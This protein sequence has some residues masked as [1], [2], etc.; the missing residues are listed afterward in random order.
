[1]P[2]ESLTSEASTL[3]TTEG[4][5]SG[6]HPVLSTFELGGLR[7]PNRVVM[8][9]M[10][11]GRTTSSN[12]APIPL[13]AEYYAQRAS[14][15]LIITGGIYIS[16]QATGAINVPGIY[17]EEHVNGWRY[18][19]DAVHAK[20]GRIFAQLGHSGGVSHP[21]LQGGDLPVAPS[22][23]NPGSKVFT[24]SGFTDTVT[25]REL[26]RGEIQDIVEDYRRAAEYAKDAGFDGVELH[27][28]NIYLIP[29]FMSDALNHRTDE[30]G[31]SPEG[32]TRFLFEVLD[33]IASVWN[34]GRIGVK[35]SPS[36]HGAGAFQAT[37]NLLPT[38]ELA[39][40]RLNDFRPAY[41][42][43]ARA[44]NDVSG[45]PLASLKDSVLQHFRPRFDGTII[46]NGGFDLNAANDAIR[47]GDADLVSFARP[48]ISNP[49]LVDRFARGLELTPSD[50]KSYYQGGALGYTSYP[51]YS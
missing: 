43:L 36:L 9:A 4:Q 14:T 12:H 11:R 47:H 51:P 49:D 20:G 15:G 32:R 41:I 28:A 30:Y 50:P 27:G 10:T 37:E 38:Y 24:P 5:P 46:G 33:A 13:E 22:A 39:F 25:P 26:T 1:M 29:Q 17:N 18:V 7:L 34:R 35:L 44:I 8:S 42:H 6:S 23:V 2:T 45:T 3:R 31:G 48:F 16:P 21:D 40:H 19:T